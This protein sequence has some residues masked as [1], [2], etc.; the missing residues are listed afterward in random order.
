MRSDAH[1]LQVEPVGVPAGADEHVLGD[2]TPVVVVHRLC[3]QIELLRRD[4]QRL[5]AE[6]PGHLRGPRAVTGIVPVV[7]APAVVEDREQQH[8]M[9]AHLLAPGDDQ[10]DLGDP[11]PV[12]VPVN[13]RARARRLAR[14][15]DG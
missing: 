11:S 14:M 1:P 4:G 9:G 13:S 3:E 12:F 15:R 2:K 7:L 6:G 5:V 10:P 8:H